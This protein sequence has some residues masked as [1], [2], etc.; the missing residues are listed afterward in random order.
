MAG[1]WWDVQEKRPWS[2]HGA[3]GLRVLKAQ[4]VHAM[5]RVVDLKCKAQSEHVGV[6]GLKDKTKSSYDWEGIENNQAIHMCVWPR[7][8]NS[9]R[10][11][12]CAWRV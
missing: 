8:S 7:I 6:G 4:T 3:G 5:W 10:T 1:R 12:T 9:T 2:L 11:N